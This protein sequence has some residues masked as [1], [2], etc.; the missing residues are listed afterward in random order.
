MK[1]TWRRDLGAALAIIG[2]YAVLFALDITC[3]IKFVTGVSCPGC[4]MTRA[5]LSL[6][7]GDPA[8]AFY[9]HPLV[10]LLPIALALYL[11]R[12]RLPRWAVRYAPAAVGVLFFV[13]YLIRMLRG[14]APDIVVFSP[15]NGLLCRLG[16]VLLARIG[17][18]V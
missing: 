4:G 11:F 9:Y 3:P 12:A 17:Y 8:R 15:E 13:V 2:F 1:E 10:W 7:E 6:L 16:A 14:C 18:S 5:C